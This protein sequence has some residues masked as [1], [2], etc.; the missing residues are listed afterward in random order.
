MG[1]ALI[2]AAR[3]EAGRGRGQVRRLE[4]RREQLIDAGDREAE[5]PDLAVAP[6][7]RCAPFDGVVAILGV[8][9]QRIEHAVR[10][11]AP[12]GILDHHRIAVARIDRGM[13]VDIG[14]RDPLVIGAGAGSGRVRDRSRR[15]GR[16][17]RPAGRRRA[18]APA[19]RSRPRSRRSRAH[20]PRCHP[21]APL[22][23][24]SLA[25][26]AA[27]QNR[28][29]AGFGLPRFGWMRGAAGRAGCCGTR[30]A[31][32]ETAKRTQFGA[33]P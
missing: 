33:V 27:G 9:P 31:S 2:H 13:V 6:G 30:D 26:F 25:R 16:C 21:P 4:G 8:E 24:A 22:L 11:V 20:R 3:I 19:R 15:G 32:G 18:S 7:L 12:A 29:G 23:A 1:E 14:L 10:G 28:C 5:T 17:R